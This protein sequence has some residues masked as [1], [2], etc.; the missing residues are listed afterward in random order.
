ML[1]MGAQSSAQGA[2]ILEI[3]LDRMV[4]TAATQSA[5]ASEYL[6]DK[7]YSSGLSDPDAAL[8]DLVIAMTEK[9]SAEA[10]SSSGWTRVADCLRSLGADDA[11]ITGVDSDRS[12]R[13]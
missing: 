2:R 6:L 3:F 4:W 7:R 13:S 10:K 9:A 12:H 1:S 5:L 11:L 8:R